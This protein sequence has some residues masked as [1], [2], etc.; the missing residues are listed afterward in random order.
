MS[1]SGTKAITVRIRGLDEPTPQS[2]L[3]PREELVALLRGHAACPILSGL[4]QYGLLDR[5][6]A[7]PFAAS[8]IVVSNRYLFDSTLTYLVSL[9]LLRRAGN[10]PPQFTVTKVGRTVFTRYGSCALIHSYRDYFERLGALIVGADQGPPPSVDRR[11]NI[12]GSGQLHASKFFPAAYPILARHPFRRCIDIGCGNGEFLAGLLRVRPDVEA[13]GVDSSRVSIETLRSRF[14]GRV[15][16]IV[17]DGMD[18][19]SWHGRVPTGPDPVIVSLW[20]VVHEFAGADMSKVVSFF[21]VLNELL[22]EADVILGEIVNLPPPLLASSHLDSIMPE[23]LLF[24][25]LSGQG[26]F[27]WHQHQ[28]MLRRIPYTLVTQVLFDEIRDGP[29][30][31]IPSSFLWHLR[32]KCQ[33][34]P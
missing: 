8:D 23:F 5:M 21:Q 26:V 28:K 20:Y 32:P 17:A 24:H 2:K 13:V 11:T 9:G 7:G 3:N 4:G 30:T 22:P 29:G 16:G 12:L 10:S 18:V 27:T 19:P 33:T 14:A 31:A 25:A 1:R 15:A 6:L 34:S